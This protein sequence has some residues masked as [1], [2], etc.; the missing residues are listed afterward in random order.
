MSPEERY[1]DEK[2]QA[3]DDEERRNRIEQAGGVGSGK[4]R[5]KAT[6]FTAKK[7]KRKK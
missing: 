3:Y 2:R 6:N 7:K 1:Q 5:R 4:I